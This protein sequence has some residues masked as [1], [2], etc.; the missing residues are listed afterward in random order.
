MTDSTRLKPGANER[1]SKNGMRLCLGQLAPDAGAI[2]PAK[3]ASTARAPVGHQLIFLLLRA[4]RNGQ[5][6]A[7]FVA[8]RLAIHQQH[9]VMHA[10]AVKVMERDMP[11]IQYAVTHQRHLLPVCESADDLNRGRLLCLALRQTPAEDLAVG[12][13]AFRRV[14]CRSNHAGRNFRNDWPALSRRLPSKSIAK[15]LNHTSF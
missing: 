9:V 12:L 3:R 15:T 4:M 5:P 14:L 6:I 11:G 1:C 10:T 8:N 7:M 13:P 2:S